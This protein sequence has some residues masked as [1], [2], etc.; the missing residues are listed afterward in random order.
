MI[1]SATFGHSN[2]I[3][4]S[5]DLGVS[6]LLYFM[7][8]SLI[9][10][11][12]SIISPLSLFIRTGL[13]SLD[14]NITPVV[15]IGFPFCKM[16]IVSSIVILNPMLAFWILFSLIIFAAFIQ[17]NVLRNLFFSLSLVLASRL[18][19]VLNRSDNTLILP[20]SQVDSLNIITRLKFDVIIF[21]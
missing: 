17:S 19:F 9:S 13:E 7:H 6:R 16:D 18:L 12:Q 3:V 2:N 4:S 21:S 5:V 20:S 15:F 11:K 14:E 1:S 8:L 10:K